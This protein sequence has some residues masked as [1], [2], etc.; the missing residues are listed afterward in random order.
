MVGIPPTT[1]YEYRGNSF[2]MWLLM[3]LA[4][5]LFIPLTLDAVVAHAATMIFGAG[6][7][8]AI[9]VLERNG[10]LP[11]P[12]NMSLSCSILLGVIGGFLGALLLPQ[13]SAAFWYGCLSFVS[14]S[15][16]CNG[17]W[18][19]ARRDRSQTTGAEL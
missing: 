19:L 9:F 15:A 5:P 6:L 10:V 13:D 14:V 17:L 16:V 1:E 3:G 12:Y 4:I 7:G 2:V 8:L 18:L 11:V